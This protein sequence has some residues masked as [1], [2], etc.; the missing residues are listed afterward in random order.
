MARP[1][2]STPVDMSDLDLE[3]DQLQAR[4]SEM[5]KG[6]LEPFP[7][8]A[9][10]QQA[11]RL[12]HL[13]RFAEAADLGEALGGPGLVPAAFA[14]TIYT[15]YVESDEKRKP[16]LFETAAQLCAQA[17]EAGVDTA[18]AH[19]MHAVSMGRYSQFI[20]MIEALAKGYGGRI[21]DAVER[22]LERSPNH[23]EGHLTLAGWHAAITDQAGGLMA[24]MLYG[25]TE[26]GADEHYAEAIRLVPD[27]PV[28]HLE[29]ARGLEVMHGMSQRAAI[30]AALE[31]ALDCKPVDAMQRLD[32]ALGRADLARLRG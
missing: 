27:S 11:W 23:A 9:Q 22:C 3:G 24:R 18:N 21:K 19:Y 6:N 1:W 7:A 25:A 13:G 32:V 14:T 4:W 5:H 28:V 29:H 31:R 30:V 17:I 16:E 26:D 15:V 10:L 8:D 20:S 2:R 12:Y